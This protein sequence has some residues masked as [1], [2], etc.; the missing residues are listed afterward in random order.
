MP[1]SSCTLAS[2]VADE[3]LVELLEPE[4]PLLPSRREPG[5]KAGM[6]LEA[7][8]LRWLLPPV[9]VATSPPWPARTSTC[10]PTW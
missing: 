1:V 6:A 5:P 9:G 4:E 3:P 8:P 10:L 7:E 2:V